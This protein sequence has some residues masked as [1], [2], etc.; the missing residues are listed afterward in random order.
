MKKNVKNV[1]HNFFLLQFSLFNPNLEEWNKTFLDSN[2]VFPSTAN[3]F[4]LSAAFEVQN[5]IYTKKS[6]FLCN[7]V[8][9][10][11]YSVCASAVL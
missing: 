2:Y 10:M 1:M 7:G 11:L 5:V 6:Q 4:D 3:F 9:H 8:V